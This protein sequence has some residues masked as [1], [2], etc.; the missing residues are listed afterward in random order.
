MSARRGLL[1]ACLAA[2]AA[3]GC[4][5][6]WL[7]EWRDEPYIRP[8][9]E[10]G[11]KAALARMRSMWADDRDMGCRALSVMARE[12]R[13]AGEE[14]VAR[15]RAR[16]LMDHYAG[17]RD[18]EVRS[19]I[20]ALCLREAG[21]GDVAVHA[22]LKSK[23][24][25]GEHPASA[26]YALAALRPAGAFE[27]LAAACARSRD[28]ELRWELLGALWLLGDRRAVPV[29]EGALAEIEA[30]WPER[31]HHMRKEDYKKAL[32]GRLVTLRAAAG[33]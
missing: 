3:A 12:A 5:Q 6:H 17:E 7:Y 15:R 30:A 13:A 32:A 33:E 28:F 20:L 10:K 24:N 26:A 11:E 22:F 18:P 8:V 16:A 27:C 31:V 14:A 9:F 4:K 29:L 25:S 21:E 2:L 23:L 1:F 19:T